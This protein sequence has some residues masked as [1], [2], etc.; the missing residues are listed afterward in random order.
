A[1][2]PVLAFTD[3]DCEPESGWLAAGLSAIADADLV[4]GVV[5]PRPDV[6][7]GPFDRTVWVT[8]PGLFETSNLFVKREWWERVGGFEELIEDAGAKAP[9]GEDAWFGW[10]VVRGGARTGFANR[11]VVHHAV[12]PRTA[13]GYL[14]AR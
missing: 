10:R 4:Q 1:S 8:M 9:F 13:G 2:A 3:A 14:A 12:L 6:V 7:L 5:R 11:A